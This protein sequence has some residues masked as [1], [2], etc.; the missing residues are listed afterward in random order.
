[1]QLDK[2]VLKDSRAFAKWA[3]ILTLVFGLGGLI[4]THVREV[5]ESDRIEAEE[6]RAWQSSPE[7]AFRFCLTTVTGIDGTATP[8]QIKACKEASLR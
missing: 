4:F 1:M 8:D 6:L 3:V 5:R 7:Y 2:E